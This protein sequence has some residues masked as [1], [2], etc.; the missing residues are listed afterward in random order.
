MDIE[1]LLAVARGSKPAD[2]VLA[3]AA[4]VDVFAGE[5]R[6][7]DI[8]V[9]GGVIAGLGGEYDGQEK[10]D[11]QGQFVCPGFIDAHVH[12]ES[13]LLRPREF[14]RA[15]VPH[16][17]TTVVTN[18]HEIANVLGLKGVLFMLEDAADLPLD[19]L[20][21]VP[22][23]VP[24]TPLATSGASLEPS[25]LEAL[26]EDPRVVGLGEVMD[27]R[28]VIQG[29][30]R[31]MTELRTFAGRPLDGHAPGVGG[32]D[33]NA[34]AATGIASDHECITV[35]EAREK[36]QAG[37]RIFLREGSVARNL[38]DLLPLVTP[39]NERRLCLCTDD[40]QPSDLLEEGSI[41]HLV[42]I[43]ISEGV[44]P[45]TAIR[46][47]TLNPAEHFR[48]D[49]R[50]AVAPG[51]R[52]DFVIFEDLQNPRPQRIYREGI[53]AASGGKLTMTGQGS[54]Y[55]QA[56]SGTVRIDWS[57]VDFRLPAGTGRARV[58]GIRGGQ[59]VTDH[60]L[61]EPSRE[62]GRP[63]AD[64]GRDLLKIAVIERHHASGRMGL[65]LVR[66]VGLCQGAIAGT[67]AHDHHNL[68]VIGADDLSMETAARAVAKIGGGLAT[69][70]GETVTALLPLPIA[71]LM[72]D[73]PAEKVRD[74]LGS[75]LASAREFGATLPD[76]FMTMSF[77]A[78]E[79]IPSLKLTDRGLVDVEEG[80]IVPLFVGA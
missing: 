33:L 42:R 17:V 13:S 15:V 7:A 35:E 10:V 60:L 2:L 5:V 53:L 39:Q 69:A 26:L 52:A 21:T 25:D 48:L 41:D 75:L 54:G 19:T 45:V 29:S 73:Q 59:L 71:G 11:L 79:V 57:R 72:S 1:D 78:L 65:G 18:P 38:R 3:N 4:L 63:V 12:V 8:A 56:M 32:R 47:A 51:R 46:M 31:L 58:I 44:P 77:M 30:P 23:C 61:L 70:A 50:G 49:D 68:V 22:S 28:G 27:F 62:K 80:R 40:R 64:P 14:A 55:S 34:Y 67:V 16:G 74:Q 76:P 24:A 37:M 66:G 36:L 9:A 43:A 20:I 6:R